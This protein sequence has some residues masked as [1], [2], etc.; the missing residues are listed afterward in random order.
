M[1]PSSMPPPDGSG[2]QP[3]LWFFALAFL[4]GAAVIGASF[5]VGS[6]S[7]AASVLGDGGVAILLF[8][9]LY[10]IQDRSYREVR[11]IENKQK[12]TAESVEAL[13]RTVQDVKEEMKA[14]QLRIDELGPATRELIAERR[15]SDN[16][17]VAAFLATPTWETTRKML[18]A[19]TRLGAVGH[20]IACRLGRS[21]QWIFFATGLR[22]ARAQGFLSAIEVFLDSEAPNNGRRD[23]SV[24]WT[25]NES[26]QEFMAKAAEK[27][28]S[29]RKYPGDS[30]FDASALLRQLGETV[31]KALDARH[32]GRDIGAV[33]AWVNPDWVLTDRG[34]EAWS[35]DFSIPREALQ[36][37][38]ENL[39]SPPWLGNAATPERD[40]YYR[41]ALGLARRLWP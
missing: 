8:L 31:Q 19:A 3:R 36:A 7:P 39:P 14:A 10:W 6:G 29:L 34:L 40:E 5:R 23:D 20:S 38:G 2:G 12:D 1:A 11:Q 37:G 17:A 15:D 21:D 13:E 33:Y 4:L 22:P 30:Y 41:V 27:L 35:G 28:K 9:P 25:Q 24:Y 18:W 16:A 26:P 32:R